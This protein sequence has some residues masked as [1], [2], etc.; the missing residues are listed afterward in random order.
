[1]SSCA[2]QAKSGQVSLRIARGHGYVARTTAV[3]GPAAPSDPARPTATRRS[4]RSAQ[5]TAAATCIG[6]LSIATTARA[7]RA[8]APN[9]PIV[10]RRASRSIPSRSPARST[11]R[12]GSGASAGETAY[13]Y[14]SR[15]NARRS[16]RA[17]AAQPCERPQC[18]ATRRDRVARIEDNEALPNRRRK[19]RRLALVVRTSAR[20]DSVDPRVS[21]PIARAKSSSISDQCDV[22]SPR[23]LRTTTRLVKRNE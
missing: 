20:N 22:T 12:F 1:M 2:T 6:P 14:A 23:S 9:P 10:V 21:Q 15:H 18:C 8:S 19:F 4:R 5:P 13:E 16:A 7:R 17:S 11:M 3:R